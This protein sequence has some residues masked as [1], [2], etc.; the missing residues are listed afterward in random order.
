MQFFIAEQLFADVFITWPW[1]LWLL[2]PYCLLWLAVCWYEHKA[3]PDRKM[4]I[5][6]SEY[7]RL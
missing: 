2:P 4:I 1:L 6:D 3:N 5:P 7:V